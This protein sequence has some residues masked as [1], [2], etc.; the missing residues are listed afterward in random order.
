MFCNDC[1]NV[2]IITA[3]N[4]AMCPAC[5]KIADR[6]KVSTGYSFKPTVNRT[7]NEHQ[8]EIWNSG[9]ALAHHF[10]RFF[11]VR[12][13]FPAIATVAHQLGGS[14]NHN[15]GRDMG[16]PNY[17]EFPVYTEPDNLSPLPGGL[18]SSIPD[19]DAPPS[20]EYEPKPYDGDDE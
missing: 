10:T 8:A 6:I 11:Q 15:I 1:S 18:V 3:P 17:D 13:F 9:N 19:E 20:P 16:S 5:G 4:N 2:S 7:T 14:G 12:G